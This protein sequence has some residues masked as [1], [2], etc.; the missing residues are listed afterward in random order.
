M[1]RHRIY[2]F[3][4]LICLIQIGKYPN[5]PRNDD[6]PGIIVIILNHPKSATEQNEYIKRS[7]HLVEQKHRYRWHMYDHHTHTIRLNQIHRIFLGWIWFFLRTAMIE[8]LINSFY[9]VK[10]H[11]SHHLIWNYISQISVSKK[12]YLLPQSLIE[13]EHSLLPFGICGHPIII[14]H[15]E[16]CSSLHRTR[17]KVYRPSQ[18]RIPILVIL[19]Q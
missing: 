5:Q 14:N 15:M 19:Y 16:M 12:C 1:I 2:P 11:S 3:V 7:H 17:P 13:I 18:L 4:I 10:W 8:Y 6:N 9:I